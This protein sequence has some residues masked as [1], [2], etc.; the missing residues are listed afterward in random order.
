MK[1]RQLGL[2]IGLVLFCLPLV[3]F[4]QEVWLADLEIRSADAVWQVDTTTQDDVITFSFT[5]FNLQDDTA[6]N[7]RALFYVPFGASYISSSHGG[8]LRLSLPPKSRFQ[9][10]LSN[11]PNMIRE[12]RRHRGTAMPH[13]A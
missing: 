3:A 5:I 10:P 7:V 8:G 12:P 2:L 1:H 4:A 11:R 9:Q 13:A 6:R